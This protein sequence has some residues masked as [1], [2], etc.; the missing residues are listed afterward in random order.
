MSMTVSQITNILIV[1]LT[2]SSGVDQRK[3]QS[4]ESLVYVRES[5]GDQWIPLTKH[6]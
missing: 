2:I 3:H 6:Q 1:C 4:T 5:T